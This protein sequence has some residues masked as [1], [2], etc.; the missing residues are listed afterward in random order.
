MQVHQIFSTEFTCDEKIWIRFLMTTEYFVVSQ[1]DEYLLLR[2][3]HF[4]VSEPRLLQ[5][6]ESELQGCQL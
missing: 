2:K 6:S 4:G 5:P 3:S 1:V